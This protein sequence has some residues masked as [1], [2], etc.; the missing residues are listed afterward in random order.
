MCFFA[1]RH[2]NGGGATEGRRVVAGGVGHPPMI[3]GASPFLLKA[4]PTSHQWVWVA[5]DV[6]HISYIAM[7]H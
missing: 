1:W 2:A 7:T 3:G 4:W 6:C 5:E